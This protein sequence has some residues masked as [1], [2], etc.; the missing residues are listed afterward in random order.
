MQ[1]IH[2]LFAL[3]LTTLVSAVPAS[4]AAQRPAK[5]DR[6]AT[7][8]AVYDSR[9]IFDSM[10]E[11]RAIESEF[12][13]EQ[14]KART[15]VSQASDSLRLAL[16]QLVKAEERLTPREREAGKLHLRASEL[17]V[18]QM[19]ENLDQVMQQRMDELS[20]PLQLRISEAVKLVRV[21]RGYNLAIDRAAVGLAIDADDAIDITSFILAELRRTPIRE[22]PESS[23]S[24]ARRPK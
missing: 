21:G 14:A 7:R 20:R 2:R 13:L 3:C 19:V 12:A 5:S 4:L 22:R 11:R 17:L 18:E 8:V 6:A 24:S 9:A 23:V 1:N 15:M 10:P 16:D